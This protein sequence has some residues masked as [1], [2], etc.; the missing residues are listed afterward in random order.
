MKTI[1]SPINKPEFSYTFRQNIHEIAF[2]DIETTGLSPKASSIYLIGIMYFNQDTNY[3][4]L[5]Q[6]FADDYSSEKKILESF[7]ETLSNYKYLYHFNGQTFDIPYVLKKCASHNVAIPAQCLKIFSDTSSTFSIDLLKFIRPLKKALSLEK[8]NQTALERW[9]G[10]ART[11]TYNGGELISVFSEYMQQKIL[12]PVNSDNLEK[13]LLLHN[14]DDI[15]MMLNICSMLTYCE[16][17]SANPSEQLLRK[18][19]MSTLEFNNTSD[20]ELSF[21]ITLSSPV[22]KMVQITAWY[23]ESQTNTFLNP[24]I[25]T[26]DHTTAT[27]TFPI[28]K[29]ALKFFFENYKEYYY[30]PKE[31]TAIH[32][33]VA[34]FVD[35]AFR[36]KA[37][38]ATCYTKK[39][40]TYLPSL[41]PQKRTKKEDTPKDV[42]PLFF[43]EHKDK[44][45]FYA[46]PDNYEHESNFWFTY[47]IAQLP[48]FR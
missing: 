8:C 15:E 12:N 33:S 29:G 2:F 37:T 35:S 45:A 42:F 20:T 38:A 10:I 7:L 22:P 18:E 4:E 43:Y 25:L 24:A 14:H 44:L 47:L 48:F 17:L 31:D 34:E 26:L 11:D 32:K 27:F 36:K 9:L 21:T 13:V 30:L 40:G 1:I 16:L 5:C 41:I 46:L 39:D 6:W 3:W 23:P 28:V 19:N